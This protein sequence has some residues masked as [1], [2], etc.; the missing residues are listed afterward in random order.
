MYYRKMD[1]VGQTANL[2]V[3]AHGSSIEVWL[4]GTKILHDDDSTF[5]SGKIGLRIT[6]DPNLPCDGVFSNVKFH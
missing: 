3:I 5:S 2:K 4:N 6:G 1:T